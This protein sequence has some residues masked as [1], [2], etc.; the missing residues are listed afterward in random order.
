MEPG[1]K[2]RV[3]GNADQQGK[4][5]HN[6]ILS[7][8]RAQAVINEMVNKYGVDRNRLIIDYKGDREPISRLHFEVNRRVDFIRVQK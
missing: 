3:V 2:I 5:D 7:K 1:L 4:V 6:V 8:N